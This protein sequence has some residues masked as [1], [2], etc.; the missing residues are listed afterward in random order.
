MLGDYVIKKS[1]S[2]AP[3]VRD[4]LYMFVLQLVAVLKS[5]TR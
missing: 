3:F 5:S 1:Q 2:S 4:A